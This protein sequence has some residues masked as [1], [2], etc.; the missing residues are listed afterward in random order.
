MGDADPAPIGE[1]AAVQRRPEEEHVVTASL[2]CLECG[3]TSEEARR[4]RA[5]VDDGELLVYC[6]WCAAREFDD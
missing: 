5:Y 2:V 6:G 4:W 1:T 3:E